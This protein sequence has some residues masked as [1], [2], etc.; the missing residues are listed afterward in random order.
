MKDVREWAD[1]QRKAL[2]E[3]AGEFAEHYGNGT[4][5]GDMVVQRLIV[6]IQRE[7]VEGLIAFLDEPEEL[8]RP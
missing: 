3:K 8:E 7:V 6:D 1:K 4:L 5:T 2:R